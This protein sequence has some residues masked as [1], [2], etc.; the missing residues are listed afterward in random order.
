M[1]TESALTPSVI[2][3]HCHLWDLNLGKHPWLVPCADTGTSL[4]SFNDFRTIQKN[5]ELHD[6]R[7]DSR[8]AGVEKIVHIQAGWDRS[9]LLGETQWLTAQHAQHGLPHAIVAYANL[10][11]PTIEQDLADLATFPLVKGIRQILAWRSDPEYQACELDFLNHPQWQNNFALLQRHHFSFDLQIYPEQTERAYA[12]LARHPE[13]PVVIEHLLQPTEH[14]TTALH[15]WQQQLQRLASLPHISIKLSGARSFQHSP[16]PAIFHH[17]IN[18][19]INTFGP[20]RCMFGSNFPVEK[21]FIAYNTLLQDTVTAIKDYSR[22]AQ[23][24]LL[25]HNAARFY[26]LTS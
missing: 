25:Y 16:S 3:S 17:L 14:T 23:Q 10:L 19:A 6:Y 18:T 11:S 22:D 2:D 13:I 9:D 20:A 5:Y 26:R 12:L 7:N 4:S 21:R 1:P 8:H 15:H 24:A